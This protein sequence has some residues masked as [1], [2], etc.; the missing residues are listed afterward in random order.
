MLGDVDFLIEQAYA[1]D[2]DDVARAY[3]EPR[4]YELIGAVPSL[5]RPE[6]LEHKVAADDKVLL[7]VRYRFSGE[8]SAA[9]RAVLDPQRLS[10]VEHSTHEVA[11]RHVDYQFVPDHYGDRFRA[12]GKCTTRRGPHGGAIRTV[13]GSIRV[14]TPIVGRAVEK[15]IVSGLRDHLT[16][17]TATVEQF[18]AAGT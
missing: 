3:T 12:S 13:E 6:V 9:A 7:K 17:E 18:L 11:R 8:L 5:G 4:L 15:A 1:A 16:N 10:W 2:P 14:K